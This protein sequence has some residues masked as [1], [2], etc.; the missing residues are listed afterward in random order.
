[1]SKIAAP[2]I[3]LLSATVSLILRLFGINKET[4]DEIYSEEE[5]K[6][7]LDVGIETGLI[8][9]TGKEMISSVFEFDDK[10]AYEIMTPRTDIFMLSINDR[11][12]EYVDELLKSR[13]SRIP[14][15]NKD[16]DDIVGVLY[17]KDFIIQAKKVGFNRV[18]VQNLLQKPFFVPESKN[19]NELFNEMQET[20]KH[21]SF[22][23]DEYG[24]V[25]GIVTTEDI[26]EEIMGAIDDEYDDAEPKMDMLNDGSYVIDGNYYLD[27]LNDELSIDLQSDDYETIG[28]FLMNEIGEISDDDSTVQQVVEIENLK[29]TIESWKERR[30]DRVI[31]EVHN[32]LSTEPEEE[33]S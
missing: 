27:D 3:F 18:N 20:K 13:F 26:V 16:S 10:L 11:V 9:E 31:L 19:I 4:I 23:I 30:I 33:Q 32:E 15:Y 12:E 6:S 25:S 5:I 2:F 21:M 28:G 17:M 8:D 29:F 24:G 7:H 14:Y 1:V 22:L